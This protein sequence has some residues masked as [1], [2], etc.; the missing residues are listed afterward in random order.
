VLW[1]FYPYRRHD[2]QVMALMLMLHPI[3]RFLLEIIRVD[4][5][6][7]WG[8]GL[9]ISQNLSIALF[10]VGVGLWLWVRKKPVQNPAFPTPG[11]PAA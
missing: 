6:P 3:S 9:S 8:T 11:A 4:E 1:S 5:S 2:G 10:A 7:V